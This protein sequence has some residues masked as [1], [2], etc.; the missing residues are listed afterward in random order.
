[1]LCL[2][3]SNDQMLDVLGAGAPGK[4]ARRG[5]KEFGAGIRHLHNYSF[6]PNGSEWSGLCVVE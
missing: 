6:Y 1:M 5:M 4:E 3:G 2:H